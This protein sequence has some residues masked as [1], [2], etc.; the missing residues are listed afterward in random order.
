[1]SWSNADLARTPATQR[2]DL[3]FD[4][5]HPRQHKKLR[6]VSIALRPGGNAEEV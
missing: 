2:E 4:L 6:V 1:M 5:V 3:F